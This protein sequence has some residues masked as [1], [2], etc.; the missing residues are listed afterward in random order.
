MKIAS[1][2]RCSASNINGRI[3]EGDYYALKT[4]EITD[5]STNVPIVQKCDDGLTWSTLGKGL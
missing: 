2:L 3:Y 4:I 1:A 5:D